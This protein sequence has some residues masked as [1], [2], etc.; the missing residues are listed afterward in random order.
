MSGL[1]GFLVKY[2][3]LQEFL[4][5]SRLSVALVSRK[6][7]AEALLIEL[8]GDP[9]RPGYKEF[10]A[11]V[12]RLKTLGKACIPALALGIP[13]PELPPAAAALVARDVIDFRRGVKPQSAQDKLSAMMS[14]AGRRRR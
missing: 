8:F 2:S 5:G 3:R 13:V 4:N 1:L 6:A 9:W 7:E 11:E 14:K 12:K 10:A